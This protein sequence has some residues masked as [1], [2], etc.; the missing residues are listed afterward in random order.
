MSVHGINIDHEGQ[1]SMTTT[2]GRTA[3]IEAAR[4]RI[5]L[6]QYDV[7]KCCLERRQHRMPCG[8]ATH[9]KFGMPEIKVCDGFR[10]RTPA[11]PLE[12]VLDDGRTLSEAATE[13]RYES[14]FPPERLKPP[15]P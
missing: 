3:M 2:E 13:K 10:L 11:D 4:L 15:K 7:C 9:Y 1:Q 8:G 6:R 12:T 14:H 5:L